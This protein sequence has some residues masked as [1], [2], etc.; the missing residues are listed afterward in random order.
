VKA[1]LYGILAGFG[2]WVF[3]HSFGIPE[4]AVMSGTAYGLAVLVFLWAINWI[5]K[6]ERGKDPSNKAII[7][8][9]IAF[10][11]SVSAF[12]AAVISTIMV[13]IKP[14]RADIDMMVFSI[15]FS[16]VSGFF[17]VIVR[18]MMKKPRHSPK[19]KRA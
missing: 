4:L 2:V 15:G 8:Y 10:T 16:C 14:M 11:M 1:I 13:S 6:K 18:S 7:F 12:F 3:V 9:V 17:S 19:V 5:P